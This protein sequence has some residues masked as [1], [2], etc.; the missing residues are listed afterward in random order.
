MSDPFR[1]DFMIVGAQKC[2]TTTLAQ[3]LQSHPALVGCTP[4]EPQFFCTSSDWRGE[5]PRYDRLFPRREGALYFEASTTY[6]FYPHRKL[7]IWDDLHE[8]NP[9]LK[10][11]YLVRD[12]IERVTS[13]YMHLYERGFIESTFEKAVVGS[14]LV[15][16]VTRYA[17]QIAPFIRRFG[18]D[19]V[20]ILF[21]DDLVHAPEAVARDVATFL[22][23]DPDGFGSVDGVHENRTLGGHKR[24]YRYDSN[25]VLQVLERVMPPLWRALADNSARAFSQKPILPLPLA[26]AVLHMLRSEIDELETITGRDLSHWR[27]VSVLPASRPGVTRTA[28]LP[29]R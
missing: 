3:I 9:D 20:R 10:I 25:P 11:L 24:N 26:R 27:T 18:D 29:S 6:T 17:S 15:L 4:K 21:F 14:P 16:D 5:L 22:G 12:P 23:I 1:V 2:G 7:E 19:R 28:A 13:A 8:Y